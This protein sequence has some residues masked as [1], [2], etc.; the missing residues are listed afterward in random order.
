MHQSLVLNPKLKVQLL[1]C[2]PAPETAKDI[3]KATN[4]YNI[5]HDFVIM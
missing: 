1:L 3:D 4:L 5:N 2:N